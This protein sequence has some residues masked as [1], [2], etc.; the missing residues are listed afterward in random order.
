[1]VDT[2]VDT[3]TAAARELW[4]DRLVPIPLN[5]VRDLNGST[6]EF[7]TDVGLP[8]ALRFAGQDYRMLTGSELLAAVSLGDHT[9]LA[10][11]RH[12]AGWTF[13]IDRLDHRLWA[14]SD[15]DAAPMNPIFVNTDITR[16][17][18]F[19]GYFDLFVPTVQQ[20]FRRIPRPGKYSHLNRLLACRDI[21]TTLETIQARLISWD[22]PALDEDAWWRLAL[23]QWTVGTPGHGGLTISLD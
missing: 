17:A 1:M 8:T 21:I 9:Y 3:P 20:L 16:F 12:Y 18:A 22:S 10:F 19:A 23:E 6:A 11:M 4:Q 7:L 13:G 15:Y 5:R 14:I 2:H